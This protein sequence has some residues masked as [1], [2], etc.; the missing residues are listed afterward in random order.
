MT[1]PVLSRF[2][3]SGPS[4]PESEQFHP[5]LSS[6]GSWFPSLD[7][8]LLQNSP[9]SEFLG[10]GVCLHEELVPIVN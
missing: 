9:G 1:S 2:L 7:D 4:D 6:F 5:I 10:L 3:L 8:L